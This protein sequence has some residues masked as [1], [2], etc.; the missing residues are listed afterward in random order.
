MIITDIKPQVKSKS[1]AS[2]FI[3]NNF[4]CGLDLVTIYK[5]RLKVG[6]EITKEKLIEI[7]KESEFNKAFDYSIDY[8]SRSYKT[9]KQV[10]DKL[11][12]KGFFIEIVDEIINK[13]NSYNYLSDTDYI[14]KY[15]ECYKDKKSVKVMKLDLLKKG[16]SKE[17]IDKYLGSISDSLE[18]AVK[19]ASKYMKN[20]SKDDKIKCY[21]YLLSKGYSYEVAKEVTNKICN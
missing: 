16:V 11:I 14:E 20:K 9:E 15:I 4:Y 7:Q 19:L 18:G 1:R 17:L 12:Q 5:Y 6:N 21:R 10:K 2:I 8:I 3:D 13:L